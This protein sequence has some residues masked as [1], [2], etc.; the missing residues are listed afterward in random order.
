[1]DLNRKRTQT[2]T[3]LVLALWIVYCVW[4]VCSAIL[5]SLSTGILNIKSADSSA[6]IVVGQNNKQS[7]YV[8]EGSAKI[9]LRA[10]V[11]QV[12]AIDG[13]KQSNGVASVTKKHSASIY[14]KP[15][16]LV[17]LPSVTDVD[18][19]NTGVLINNGLTTDQIN[20]LENEFFQFKHTEQIVS[21]VA[22]SV[23][24]GPYN[25]NVVEPFVI[26]FNVLIDGVNYKAS[27]S[28]TGLETVQLNLYSSG[29]GL[30]FSSGGASS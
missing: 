20:V 16:E 15:P 21:V 24:L 4:I 7:I 11:Y 27:V 28:Y 3:W 13:N 22:N 8:G 5:T 6:S 25:P 26:D 10:G 9:R 12:S 23:V 29:G 18:F 19:M 1:M 30:V 2:I 14:L 17:T